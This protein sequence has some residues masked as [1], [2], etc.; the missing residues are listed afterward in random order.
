MLKS[1]IESMY[2]GICIQ[3]V[4]IIDAKRRTQIKLIQAVNVKAVKTFP[5]NFVVVDIL[6]KRYEFTSTQGFGVTQLYE[7]YRA[8]VKSLYSNNVSNKSYFV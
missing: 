1:P 6:D 2:V 8:I 7:D 5:S 4:S 3:G